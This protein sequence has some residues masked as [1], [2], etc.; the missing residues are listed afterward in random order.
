[1]AI[2]Q[3][4]DVIVHQTRLKMFKDEYYETILQHDYGN[5]NYGSQMD[6][7]SIRNDFVT[8]EYFDKKDS[9]QYHQALL[10]KQLVTSIF[11]GKAKKHH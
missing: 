4:N 1:M 3:H 9:V 5:C 10:P 6:R 2:E 7:L 8:R 11:Y